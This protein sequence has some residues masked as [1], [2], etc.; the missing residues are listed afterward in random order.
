MRDLPLRQN[1]SVEPHGLGTDTPL[2]SGKGLG[3]HQ[4][5]KALLEGVDLDVWP[6]RTLVVLGA[7]GAG[8]SLLVR[9]LH[10][11][12]RPSAGE[13]QWQGR[14][15]NRRSQRDQAM[16]F[17][18][19]V[20]MRRTAIGNLNFAATVRGI[21]GAKK[22]AAVAEA[23]SLAR[24]EDA[25]HRP[26]HLLSGGEQ[27]RLA[28]VRA[29]LC[30]PKLL[31]LDEPTASLDPAATQAVEALVR[32]AQA[33]GVAVVLVTHNAGQARR[34]GDQGLFLHA[35]RVAETGRI[36]SMLSAPRSEAVQAW[37]DGRLYVTP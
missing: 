20:M 33:K 5:G 29:L 17:Q 3:Y 14:P 1:F 28:M 19:P 9:I 31:F 10:R 36:A 16:V 24:L 23:L 25:A 13:I 18:R 22:R 2:L 37:C 26:A 30:R 34:L 32:T 4:N 27:Q 11:L 21:R 12:I 35:G 7:N 8:K 6:G 15:L